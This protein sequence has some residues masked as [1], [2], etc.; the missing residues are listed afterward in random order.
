MG[1]ATFDLPDD[2][3]DDEEAPKKRG[4][5]SEWARTT[6]SGKPKA[7]GR[8]KTM[9][10]AVFDRARVEVQAMIDEDDW[11]RCAARHVVALYDVMHAKA[12]GFEVILTAADRHRATLRA[13]GFVKAHFGGDYAKMV[14]Y[15][16]WLWTEEIRYQKWCTE[17]RGQAGRRMTH[18]LM[19]STSKLNDY[20]HALTNRKA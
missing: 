5:L 17:N 8:K 3:F 7:G 19:L 1:K 9:A 14:E 12:Y 2:L 11:G 6:R 10:A 16:R 15:L 20:R 13:G 4:G 18:G